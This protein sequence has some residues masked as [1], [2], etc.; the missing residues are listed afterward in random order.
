MTTTALIGLGFVAATPA[1]LA[2]STDQQS[3]TAQGGM[4]GSAASFCEQGWSKADQDG[5]G[6]VTREEIDALAR[7]EFQEID[8]DGDGEITQ[9]EFDDCMSSIREARMQAG[10][11][12]GGM[13]TDDAMASDQQQGAAAGAG[14][15]DEQAF[16]AADRDQDE[17]LDTQEY[18]QAVAEA[19]S[20]MQQ[21]DQQGAGQQAGQQQAGQQ[22]TGQQQTGQQQAAQQQ[23]GQQQDGQ[24]PQLLVL[25]QYVLVPTD[26]VSD[27]QLRQMSQDEL[28]AQAGRAFEDMDR[29]GDGR[30]TKE[31]WQQAERG[32]GLGDQ[33]RQQSFQSLDQD[34]SGGVS[35][36]EYRQ[37]TVQAFTETQ[38]RGTGQTQ[39]AA[40][41]GE[42][43]PVI[44]Y[45]LHR[46]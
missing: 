42:G 8:A 16:T 7:A 17:Q 23:T 46:Y 22:Q 31:E 25:R 9:S 32:S 45:R 4:S 2:Q 33:Q 14:E 3:A 26:Q 5:D 36:E 6:N 15:R 41:D 43:V 29:D 20:G 12:D 38:Q 13:Q 18:G 44:I 40:R 39:T 19:Y 10:Q 30:I 35:E 21:G 28:G 1:A 24:S 11:D 27:Q 37:S 34:A